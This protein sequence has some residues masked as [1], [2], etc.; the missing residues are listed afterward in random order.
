ML[1]KDVNYKVALVSGDMWYSWYNITTHNNQ[2]KYYNDK[3]WVIIHI[4]PGSYNITDLNLEMK[5]LV[6]AE[7]DDRDS[8][9]IEPN[10]N[11]S[12]SRVILG[13]DYKVDFTIEGGL[14]DVLEFDANVLEDGTHDSDRQ[15]NITN[16]HS[17]LIRCSL[18]SSSYLNGSTSD[19]IYSF[20]P[21]KPPGSL[22]ALAP[23]QLIYIHMS[24][25]DTLPSITMRVT[26][27]DG[28]PVDFNGE[29]VT[30]LLHI[31]KRDYFIWCMHIEDVISTQSVISQEDHRG[32]S[33]RQP[34]GCWQEYCENGV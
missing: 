9:S 11:T 20:S 28:R 17:I 22:L 16:I 10:Y 12:K 30:F 2:F 1:K 4:P 6:K 25:R 29:R 5:R 27:Q 13:E 26:D 32:L 24:G 23:N 19:V 34:M 21:N 8:I 33:V 3:E 31:K 14:R 18:V 7:G 15:V